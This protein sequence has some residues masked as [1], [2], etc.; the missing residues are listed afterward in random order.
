M[1]ATNPGTAAPAQLAKAALR[2]L[3]LE[4]REPTP[5]NYALAYAAEGGAAAAPT[6]RTQAPDA[7][8][9]APGAAADGLAWAGLIEKAIKGLERSGRGWTTARKKESLQR[10]LTGSRSDAARLQQRLGQ[11]MASWETDARDEPALEDDGGDASRADASPNPAGGLSTAAA[12]EV[13]SPGPEAGDHAETE[14]R[15]QPGD[16]AV[17]GMAAWSR[18]TAQL[19]STVQAALPPGE[20]RGREIGGELE[21]LQARLDVE[22]PAD[23]LVDEI[24]KACDEARRLLQHRHH[25]IT[26]LGV[27]TQELTEGLTQLA[28]DGS[29]AQG[30]SQAMRAELD[31]GLTS[32]SVKAASELLRE[33]RE[34]Q[35]RLQVERTQVRE[36]L[37]ASIHQ[38][39]SEIAGLGEQTGRFSESVG[40]YADAID[41][42][43]SFESL[44]GAVREMVA[45]SRTVQEVVSRTQLRLQTQ[46][47][48]ADAM[49]QRVRALEDDIRRLSNEVS[50][51]PLT[52]VANRRGLTSAFETECARLERSAADG[53]APPLSIGLIDID[54]FKRLNDQHG[55]AR[56]DE[57]LQFLASEVTQALRPGDTLARYGGEEFVV[58]LPQTEI[59]EAERALT[60]LQR[61]LSASL[62][63]TDGDAKVFVTFSAGV[64][65]YRPGERLE[66]SLERADEALYEAKRTGKNRTC[67]AG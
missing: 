45:E 13:G 1:S 59:D 41:Q 36:A 54:N 20:G 53:H 40:R 2:R 33:T 22:G 28:E 57:A 62:F 23:G 56:G 46:H 29:W 34:R 32:R 47:A 11:L 44:A 50:T 58:L 6:P 9:A 30:Q 4:R 16:V 49:Q 7:T 66:Q 21:T 27:L 18:V 48:E 61:H 25:L 10:V 65:T 5:E 35:Q 15:T 60:R 24:T 14:G 63:M 8:V 51:D 31:A 3:A 67:V 19:G 12:Q 42:A 17:T 64:T 55:H 43:D 38:M 26:Q 39:L 52:Q 37:K